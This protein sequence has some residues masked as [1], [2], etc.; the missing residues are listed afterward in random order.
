MRTVFRKISLILVIF[1]IILTSTSVVLAETSPAQL[2]IRRVDQ[3]SF[4]DNRFYF[5]AYN[6]N[7]NPV[8]GLTSADIAVYDDQVPVQFSLAEKEAGV[9]VVFVIDAGIGITAKGAT[10]LTRYAEMKE[11]INSFVNRMGINSSV[12]VLTDENSNFRIISDFGTDPTKIKEQLDAYNPNPNDYSNGVDAINKAITELKNINDDKKEFIVLLTS[13]LEREVTSSMTLFKENLKNTDAPIVSAV[14]FRGDQG[15]WSNKLIEISTLARGEFLYYNLKTRDTLDTFFEHIFEWRNQYEVTYRMPNIASGTHEISL[16]NTANTIQTSAKY[17]LEVS[18]PEVRIVEPADDQVIKQSAVDKL[19]TKVQVSFPD[20]LTRKISSVV[21]YVDGQVLG[22]I[23][24]PQDLEVNIPWDS[25]GYKITE[26]APLQMEVEV[27]DEVGLTNRSNTIVISLDPEDIL[28]A[29]KQMS[30]LSLGLQIGALA[31]AL[32]AVVLVIIFRRSIA[33]AGGTILTR[34]GEIIESIT[35]PRRAL[36]AKATLEVIAGTESKEK[37]DI[38]G[39]TPIGR[40]RKNADLV[41]HAAEENSPI[42]RLHC[43]I[44]DEED[45]FYIRDEDSQWGTYLNN[46][47]LDPLDKYQL[48]EGDEITLAPLERGGIRVRFSLLQAENSSP[49]FMDDIDN[50]FTEKEDRTETH[51]DFFDG[52][53]TK[54]TRNSFL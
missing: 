32:A 25:S 50:S 5:Y 49:N 2:E 11:F 16:T 18:P 9:R 21:L 20:G 14:L 8:P 51:D 4:P 34:A 52:E 48:S 24:N 10:G 37:I 40:S 27:T 38:Y 22:T 53:T 39:T 30:P 28:E 23:S 41:F 45:V 7:G 26:R 12:M 54:P 36:T 17:N 33:S 6:V 29:A 44:L 13:G 31:L 35:K 3:S 46:N 19:N 42:S 15:N 47:K 43:T 1:F